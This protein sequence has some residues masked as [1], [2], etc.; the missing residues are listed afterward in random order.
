MRY[1]KHKTTFFA[2]NN[3][4]IKHAVEII[5]IDEG[6][7]PKKFKYI[8]IIPLSGDLVSF[9]NRRKSGNKSPIPIVSSKEPNI[10]KN[11]NI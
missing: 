9:V 1:T 3:N 7:F 2:T 11:I 4:P 5:T 6:E 10:T 8:C